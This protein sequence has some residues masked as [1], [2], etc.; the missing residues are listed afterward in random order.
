MYNFA[1][2]FIICVLVYF[3]GDAVSNLTK[4][5]IPSVFVTAVVVLLLFW[6]MPYTPVTVGGAEANF[7]TNI[8]SISNL[9][10]FGSTIGIY[11][12]LVHMGSVIS[13]KQLGEQWKTIVICLAG[14]V[15]MCLAS[16]FIL[17]PIIGK[18]FVVAGLP[19][20]TGGIV[21][22]T[23]M[24]S[25]A[26]AAGLEEAALF[27]IA[28]YCVQ[29]FAG[30]PLTAVCLQLYGKKELKNY[31]GSKTAA[32]DAAVDEVNGKL[33]EKAPAKK[34][35]VPELPAKWNNSVVI[36]GKLAVGAWIATLL[37]M[38]DLV[39]GEG[40]FKLSGAVWALI[41][42]IVFTTLGILD[43]NAL[44][45][46]NSY[47]IVMFA[48]MMYI[49]DGLKTATPEMLGG[50]IGPMLLLIVVGVAGMALLCFVAAKILK[51]DFCLAFATA[52]TALYGFPP[53]AVIT[54][55]TCTA[56]A[57]GDEDKKAYLMSK[58]FAPMIVGGFTTVTIT[59]VVIAGIFTNFF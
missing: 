55:N 33:V 9:V 21:A 2:A 54:E 14:L 10:P 12:L 27:A 52:L 8:V 34:K 53:N 29:G 11:L 47:G 26:Q 19:P 22:A 25:A 46:A 20:L 15:G 43:E 31:D 30:Y 17:C 6:Y 36:L 13:L 35:L 5:W 24:Q 57:A 40:T 42:G 18:D 7:W 37:G 3:I 51:M 44:N 59:S 39:P 45:K 28:M 32:S 58:M 38:V 1:L 56:L 4:A 49:F 16:W 50:I 48:L 41:I 23:T